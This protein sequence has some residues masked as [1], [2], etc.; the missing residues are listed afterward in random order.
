VERHTVG[1]WRKRLGLPANTLSVHRRELIREKSAEQLRA[2]G[3]TTLAELRAPTFRQRALASGG[4]ADLRPRAVQMLNALWDRGPMTRR[5]LADVLGMPWKGSRKS[6]VSND[7]EGSYLAHLTRRGLV[8]NLGRVVRGTGSGHSACLYAL[9]FDIERGV[10][11]G[12][13]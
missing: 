8:V 9:A 10:T 7:P 12:T 5:E 2:A 6:L 1:N 4:P 13:A 11:N 3:L